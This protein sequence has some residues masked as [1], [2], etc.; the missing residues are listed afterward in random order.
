MFVHCEIGVAATER[1]AK[2]NNRKIILLDFMPE[3]QG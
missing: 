3:Y 1:P 2:N